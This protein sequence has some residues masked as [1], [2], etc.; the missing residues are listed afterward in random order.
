MKEKYTL[1]MPRYNMDTY[2]CRWKVEKVFYT[3]SG[4]QQ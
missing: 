2:R 3:K 1:T 4:I